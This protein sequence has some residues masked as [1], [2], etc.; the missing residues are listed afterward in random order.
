MPINQKKLRRAIRYLHTQKNLHDPLYQYLL[1]L[2]NQHIIDYLLL[3]P[4]HFKKQE[5]YQTFHKNNKKHITKE[6]KELR[7][8]HA[9]PRIDNH[10]KGLVQQQINHKIR[11][12]HKDPLVPNTPSN[13]ANTYNLVEDTR[14]KT[15]D[16]Y[17]HVIDR[18]VQKTDKR[19]EQ[20]RDDKEFNRKLDDYI[21]QQEKELAR[22]NKRIDKNLD[23][24]V[25]WRHE[26]MKQGE[27]RPLYKVWKQTPNPR[28]RHTIT[29]GQVVPLDMKF[30]VVNDKTGDI[31]YLDHPG[32]WVG[33]AS[34]T[35]NCLCN[36]RFTNKAPE[37]GYEELREELSNRSYLIKKE[38]AQKRLARRKKDG[39]K[40]QNE[41]LTESTKKLEKQIQENKENNTNPTEDKNIN[42]ENQNNKQAIQI[43]DL[44]KEVQT[45]LNDFH[46]K[47]KYA[48]KEHAWVIDVETGEIYEKADG[49]TGQ[50]IT[51]PDL[52]PEG[53]KVVFIHNH[54]K[55]GYDTL[56]P[57]DVLNTIKNPAR[58]YVIATNQHRTHI[59]YF[60]GT[61]NGH[62]RTIVIRNQQ[63]RINSIK[64]EH[65]TRIEKLRMK[66]KHAKK[67]LNKNHVFD[68]TKQLD[69]ALDDAWQIARLRIQSEID[70]KLIT[71]VSNT[72]N[73][74]GVM[75]WEIQHQNT[76]SRL[77]DEVTRI[78]K[79]K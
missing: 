39:N 40:K 50:V 37:K 64:K 28:T 18:N 32:D 19:L 9:G 21:K 41:K 8:G 34:N 31:D 55:S 47:Y 78:N 79:T 74:H 49:T 10:L 16:Q 53:R 13:L 56:S 65:D 69:T 20:I 67:I 29:D 72:L 45:T 43:D 22:E 59:T 52:I 30:I 51:H 35:A 11:K 58:Q 61:M 7:T 70:D 77:K 57:A 75:T 15:K 63:S 54:P 1:E 42:K 71:E 33:T 60:N 14:I 5:Y 73:N 46:D 68:T 38:L 3:H 27:D 76:E 66:F 6:V 23:N 24:R 44:P 62:D 48:E 4:E 36:I 17:T 26:Q 12:I 25:K 2:C